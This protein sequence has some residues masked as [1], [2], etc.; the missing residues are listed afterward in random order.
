MTALENRRAQST[1]KPGEDNENVAAD[2]NARK[3]ATTRI[4]RQFAK[5]LSVQL[6]KVEITKNMA[7]SRLDNMLG[8]EFRTWLF[9]NS[10]VDIRFF[11]VLDSGTIIERLSENVISAS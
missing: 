8:T 2:T 10:K 1:E 7:A 4:R 3:T 6:E 11:G 5:L 9:Q